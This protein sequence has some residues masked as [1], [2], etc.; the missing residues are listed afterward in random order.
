MFDQKAIYDVSRRN[1]YTDCHTYTNINRIIAQVVS[2]IIAPIRF[3]SERNI[4][5]ITL[6]TNLVPYPRIAY[7]LVSCAPVISTDK[8]CLE[9]FSVKKKYSMFSRRGN[10]TSRKADRTFL[11]DYCVIPRYRKCSRV[12]VHFRRKSKLHS[13]VYPSSRFCSSVVEPTT[14][15]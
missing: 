2:S 14:Q 6:Q 5:L 15:F 4:D 10:V 7:P 3:A 13:A 8:A 12:A 9:Q 11:R 1:W